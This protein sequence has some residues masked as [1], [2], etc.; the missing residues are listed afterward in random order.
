MTCPLCDEVATGGAL[1]VDADT[2]VA[3]LDKHS[4]SPGHCL[5][6]PRRHV[7]SVWELSREDVLA[8]YEVMAETRHIVRSRF[9]PDGYNIGVN[10]G[11]AA[12]QTID[13]LHVHLIPR[14]LGDNVDPRG[15]IRWILPKRAMHRV[16]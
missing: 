12:G 1:I 16:D 3:L 8:L 4:V 14:Y 10:A 6:L 15:G 13:H 2:T 11:K 7:D 5:I 9:E